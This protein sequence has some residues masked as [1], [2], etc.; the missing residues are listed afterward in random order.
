MASRRRV[1]YRLHF[2]KCLPPVG[3]GFREELK[4]LSPLC[5]SLYRDIANL[6]VEPLDLLEP[7]G[8]LGVHLRDVLGR[9]DATNEW[10]QIG[11]C[12]IGSKE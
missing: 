6:F 2:C 9:K 12:I 7:D 1:T 5:I 8:A 10:S 3:S 11:V 4:E